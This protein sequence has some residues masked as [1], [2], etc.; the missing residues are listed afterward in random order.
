MLE[1]GY[2]GT[3]G[4]RL[5]VQRLPNQAAPGSAEAAAGI[6][7]LANAVGFTLDDSV[8][9]SIYHAGQV[10]LMRRMRAGL[11]FNSFYTFGKSIDDVSTF[12]GGR[13]VVV[14]D[15]SNL[16]AER[17]ISSFNRTHSWTSGFMF[18]SPIGAGTSHP[19]KGVIGALLRDWM[20]NSNFTV[21]SGAPLTAY[22]LGNRSSLGGTGVTGSSRADATGLPLDTGTGYFNPLAFALPAATRYG[23]AGRNTI[24]GPASFVMSGSA[25]RSFRPFGE[26]RSVEFRLEAQNLLNAV[27][28]TGFGTTVNAADYGLASQA[29]SMRRISAEIRFRF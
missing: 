7:P 16:R 18:T 21:A 22:I 24:T 19:P 15:N 2:L 25:G 28:V 12:G 13:A 1:G 17:G 20:L 4:S 11:S 23:N 9:N 14:Q 3:K 8:G 10:R 6:L 27:N 29:G 26:R 5:D